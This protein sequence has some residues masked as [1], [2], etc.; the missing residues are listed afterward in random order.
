MH[1]KTVILTLVL[2]CLTGTLVFAQGTKS[3]EDIPEQYKWKPEHI[4][5]S[6]EDWQKD[7]DFLKTTVDDLAAFKGRF[8][9]EKAEDPAQS[10]IAYND[11]AEEAWKKFER[12]WTYV[13]YNSDVDLANSVWTGRLQQL[14][15]MAVDYGQKL[16]WV[17]P[18]LLQIPQE[19]MHQYIAQNPKLEAY[20]K[21]YDDLYARQEHVLSEPEE[22]IL[23]LS[24]N[25][26]G[27]SSDVYG[28]LTDVDMRWG[29]ILD[30]NG[31]SVE[32]SDASW[33]T[34]RANP[35]RRV[36]EDFFKTLFTGY[37][38]YGTT[39]AALMNGNVKKNVYLAQARNYENTLQAALKGQFIPE[40][41]YTNLVETARKNTAPLHKYNEVRKRLLGV[42]AL[43]HWD[44]YVGVM[45][46]P[47]ERYTWE[48]G[49]AMV[50]DA[51]KPLGQQYTTD[52]TSGLNP[53][54]GWVDPF[55]SQSK[56]GGAYSSGSYGT[57][58]Y[59]LYNFDYDKGLSLD[60]VSTIAHEVGHAMHSYYSEKTQ[61]F[62]NKDYAIFNAEVAST[63]NEAIMNHKIL[64]QAR[65]E[66]KKA[67]GEAK[68]LAKQKL[69]ALLENNISG[70][71]DTF[72]RQT[73]FA[74]WEWEVNKMAENGQPITAE[75]LNELY[76]NLYKEFQGPVMEFTDLSAVEWSYIPHFYRGYYVFS[77]ATSY[78]AAV[79]LASDIIAESQG[80]KKKKGAADRYLAYL[81]SGSAKHPVELLKD[82]GVDMTTAA[83]VEAFTQWFGAMVNELDKL[84]TEK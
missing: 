53:G 47:E 60:D 7:M 51:L 76:L 40:Q 65:Q 19:T 26:T 61:P 29:Y 67:K 6:I 73:M 13:M 9:G 15:M 18:E 48:Q 71:R 72:Y 35:N 17:D 50:T 37:K 24:G 81:A 34:W 22:R 3:R 11:L 23:A 82:A 58:P 10:L 46:L 69:M 16:A 74:T 4:Y 57:H 31:D 78:A 25:V 68:K 66:Y 2:T 77:Y 21:A 49:V 36:R 39:M 59:M 80:D 44:Y 52:I 63:T 56:R 28:K 70:A 75:A 64:E 62:P 20:R 38:N 42:D 12:T 32:V 54:S 55:T 33:V 79:A 43:R 41:V 83:P 5:A 14:Q 84:S 30:E 8:A 45:D 1:F 27:T